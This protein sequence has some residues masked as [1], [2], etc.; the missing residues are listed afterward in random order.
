LTL[1]QVKTNGITLPGEKIIVEDG[2][3][4]GDTIDLPGR[5]NYKVIDAQGQ[6]ICGGVVVAKDVTAPSLQQANFNRDTLDC[7]D[8]SFVLKNPQT[9][10]HLGSSISPKT[11][12]NSTN[13]SFSIA[14]NGQEDRVKNLG[15]PVFVED[16]QR[17]G[18]SFTLKWSDQVY[19][20]PCDSVRKTGVFAKIYRH[21]FAIDC[22]G[23]QKDTI[24]QIVFRATSARNFFVQNQ[25]LST[26]K[27]AIQ[28]NAC[29][30]QATLNSNISTPYLN[31]YFNSNDFPRRYYLDKD[32]CAYLVRSESQHFLTKDTLTTLIQRRYYIADLCR[33]AF[34]TLL[35]ELN[36]GDFEKPKIEP[37]KD[38][39]YQ[40]LSAFDCTASIFASV[41]GINDIFG[42]KISDNCGLA[43]INVNIQAW[44]YDL[45][46][47]ALNWINKNYSQVKGQIRDLPLGTFRMIIQAKDQVGNTAQD[48]QLLRIVDKIA[49]VMI[50]NDSLHLNLINAFDF[51]EGV[52]F[53]D[54]ADVDE[55]SKDNCQL[56]SL[57][58]RRSYHL[59]CESA[60]IKFGFDT[61]QNG[62]IDTL[63][64]FDLNQDGDIFDFG[65]RF[66]SVAGVMMTP[67]A[68][69]LPFFCCDAQQKLLI[70][71]VGEDAAGNRNSCQASILNENKIVFSS[72]PL[73]VQVCRAPANVSINCGDSTLLTID[74]P[75]NA[76]RNFGGI[77]YL[78]GTGCAS[79]LKYTLVRNP[80]TNCDSS[81]ILRTWSITLAI[82]GSTSTFS[83]TCTQT[84]TLTS[85]PG[86]DLELPPDQILN[87]HNLPGANIK[88]KPKDCT[89]W[90]LKVS[91]RRVDSLSKDECFRIYRAYSIYDSC[92]FNPQC[93]SAPND[94]PVFVIP[95]S[96]FGSY[97]RRPIFFQAR[98]VS[99]D[100]MS[101]FLSPEGDENRSND[102]LVNQLMPLCNQDTLKRN[103]YLPQFSYTQI[104]RVVDDQPPVIKP[105][106]AT[107]P[108]FYQDSATCSS[109]IDLPFIATDSCTEVS[110]V[111]DRRVF[112]A[113]FQTQ[114]ARNFK[115]PDFY[116]PKWFWEKKGAGRFN[117]NIRSIPPGE[118]DLIV[119]VRDKCNN[120]SEAQRIPFIIKDTLAP[121]PIVVERFGLLLRQ[122]SSGTPTTQ[123]HVN[124]LIRR[125]VDDCNG[126][127]PLKSNGKRN[128]SR[129]S[130]NRKGEKPDSS[131][132]QLALFCEDLGKLVEIEVWAWDE[133][134]NRASS[135]VVM[136]VA[137]DQDLC[138]AALRD[139]VKGQIITLGGAPLPEVRV[140]FKPELGNNRHTFT[141]EIGNFSF[142]G[143]PRNQ[144]LTIRPQ[145]KINPSDGVSTFDLVLIQKHILNISPFKDPLKIIASDVNFSGSITTLDLIIIRKL[146]LGIDRQFPSGQSWRF[147]DAAFRFPNPENPFE[148]PF[149]DSIR[150]SGAE[151]HQVAF[152]AI[153]LGDPSGNGGSTNNFQ[154]EKPLEIV[155][156]TPVRK[157]ISLKIHPNPSQQEVQIHLNCPS[158]G[159]LRLILHDQWGRIIWQKQMDFAA[160]QQQVQLS[161]LDFPDKGLFFLEFSGPQFQQ[162]EKVLRW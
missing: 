136:V 1:Q 57:L 30:P 103:Q 88:F 133:M 110:G 117:I 48:T 108:V 46:T 146:I 84:I 24:Q 126:Q 106:S 62:K 119:V 138:K 22:S 4:N 41:S 26:G 162:V 42:I 94:D 92:R 11:S 132:K 98:R 69:R 137:D 139:E 149:P 3:S 75:L 161:A 19:Y 156:Q 13:N 159:L 152:Y 36:V 121:K 143:L 74:K 28:L 29:S 79:D 65:E 97:G 107:L 47:G 37:S 8:L 96:A 144:S 142:V 155:D 153:K 134:G 113:P 114:V 109:E 52:G 23:N 50:C 68:P 104:I 150:L 63:D 157:L 67:L 25:S 127:G 112:V 55:G 18:C 53:L 81:T 99:L 78:L 131:Q 43:S 12:I 73:S 125:Q 135:T 51:R 58:I 56:K 2:V 101:Y 31:S 66:D 59:D 123:L 38:T 72:N 151:N 118:H 93:T 95:R 17:Q 129:Y 80:R 124:S 9:I 27:V 20:F 148:A 5:H 49:P 35:L 115:S 14:G 76:N 89:N 90:V 6:V 86:F 21:W 15:Y 91:E 122:D 147:V 100:S 120:L 61:D 71:L 128:I 83:T 160:G 116:D 87:C 105:L 154:I 102:V 10:G 70:E 60:F 130:L 140:D 33:N 158:A 111:V 77:N 40:S 34:D 85:D 145:L 141:D 39:V 82:P 64:G 45:N 54:V 7:R 44:E 16:C 32:P